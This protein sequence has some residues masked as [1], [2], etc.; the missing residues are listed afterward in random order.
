MAC[1]V[2]EGVLLFGVLMISGYLYS[3][4]TQQRHA[5][6]GTLGLQLFLFTILGIYFVWFWSRGSGQ[7]VAMK[8]WHI[9]L[10]DLQGG[11]ISERQAL[12]R[13]VLS[14][15]WFIPALAVVHFAG[16][17]GWGPILFG[18]V[19]GVALYGLSSRL[20]PDRQFWHDVL[21]GTRLVRLVSP[22]AAPS[23]S[24]GDSSSMRLP[25]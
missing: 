8:T 9:A 1:M 19:L 5:L 21:C 2:Y 23:P 24:A 12:A 14:W 15:L 17:K 11:R 6:V 22:P 18:L 10:V 13:Y 3:S 20:R 25:N 7:T 16:L 4:L